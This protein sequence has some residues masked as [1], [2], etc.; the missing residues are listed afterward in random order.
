MTGDEVLMGVIGFVLIFFKNGGLRDL[1][2]DFSFRSVGDFGSAILI[3]RFLLSG[4]GSYS[5]LFC[6]V[7]D[8]LLC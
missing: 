5:S 7:A 8:E 2:T 6:C 4:L 3:L 1:E